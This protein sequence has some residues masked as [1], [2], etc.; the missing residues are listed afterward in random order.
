MLLQKSPKSAI[1]TLHILRY[2]FLITAFF[3]VSFGFII[4]A[5]QPG[6]VEL[7][8]DRIFLGLY[9]LILFGITFYIRD[10]AKIRMYFASFAYICTAVAL[11][12]LYLNNYSAVYTYIFIIGVFAF[13]HVLNTRN[14]IMIY[15]GFTFL[16]ASLLTLILQPNFVVFNVICLL[17]ILSYLINRARVISLEKEQ[18][19]AAL[20]TTILN[21]TVDAIFLVKQNGKIL[22]SNKRALEIF[23][24]D[25]LEDFKGLH[26]NALL[27]NPVQED[28]FSEGGAD[29]ERL[30][31]ELVICKTFNN[32][33]FWGDIAINQIENR[34]NHYLL[35]K[36]TDIDQQV[37]AQEELLKSEVTLK[38]ILENNKDHIWLIDPE[39]NLISFNNIFKKSI[40]A[41]FNVDLSQ[42]NNILPLLEDPK[43]HYKNWKSDYERAFAGESFTIEETFRDADYNIIEVIQVSYNPVIINNNVIGVSVFLKDITKLRNKEIEYLKFRTAIE[44][45]SEAIGIADLKGKSLYHNAAYIKLFGYTPEEVNKIGLTSV[46]KDVDLAKKIMKSTMEGIPWSGEIELLD[47]HKKEYKIYL[48]SDAIK[49][50]AGNIIG[51]IGLHRDITEEKLNEERIRQSEEKYRLL[52]ENTTDL[53]CL[54]NLD[55][56]YTYVSP[57]IKDALGYRPEELIGRTPYEFIHPEDVESNIKV[58]HNKIINNLADVVSSCRMRRKDNT[59]VW[60]ETIA[61][62]IYNKAKEPVALQ[63]SS[64]DIS[65]WKN[66]EEELLKAKNIAEDATKAKSEFLATMSH[67]IRT[68]LNAVIGMTDLLLETSLNE[69]QHDIAETIKIS[70]ENLLYVINDILDYSK[71]EAG[72]LEIESESVNLKQLV[73][74]VIE[75]Q[76]AK[77]REKDLQ[78]ISH[79]EKGIPEFILSDKIRLRQVLLNLVNN[80][81]KFTYQGSVSINVSEETI[82]GKNFIKFSVTDTG[83]GIPNEKLG[84]LFNYFTQVDSSTTRKFG[85]TGLGLAISK[86]IVM[87]MHGNIEV[88]SKEGYGST[89]SFYI[90]SKPVKGEKPTVV[91]ENLNTENIPD[92]KI[93]MAEDNLINQKVTMK[94]LEG[95]NLKIDIAQNG[96]EAI[97]MVRENEY[98]LILMDVQMPEM[99]GLEATEIIRQTA[100]PVAKKPI[101]I[102]MTANAFKEDKD[103]CINAGMDD[104][105]SK[106]VQK[107][108]IEGVIRKWFSNSSILNN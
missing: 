76:V 92:L 90:L 86:K 13:N 26:F 70:G 87:M 45:T 35:I 62:V 71:I 97:K 47:K 8:Y 41:Q 38:A 3:I 19:V 32:R 6:A 57:S 82:D 16:L 22:G 18:N 75:M 83:I 48:K 9:C 10:I 44:S 99:D 96:I 59:Y 64:R 72:S 65:A 12:H 28:I 52:S 78:L 27:K 67:E 43:V 88:Q 31:R 69:N 100:D 84:R 104:Y 55:G 60:I 5:F 29:M 81:V 93:L 77:A 85:G 37:K 91:T 14:G 61:K 17:L 95:L 25:E 66:A 42:G 106:P 34:N 30:Y 33:F 24:A 98:D 50:E 40:K 58:V 89:F 36:I 74:E 79:I 49:D 51:I 21:E 20:M 15:L 46:F 39:Y 63:T 103:I 1:R 4:P 108:D 102:A 54:H 80:A 11:F 7:I 101:I 68:P 107:K 94:I 2:S 56:T 53:I 105:L 73:E 23:K